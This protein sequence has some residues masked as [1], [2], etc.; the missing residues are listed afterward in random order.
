MV[1]VRV[2][3][4]FFFWG[5]AS[6]L[7]RFAPLPLSPL[8]ISNEASRNLE[9]KMCFGDRV[10]RCAEIE[11]RDDRRTTLRAIEGKEAKI[12]R[13]VFFFERKES[14]HRSKKLETLFFFSTG[15][16]ILVSLSF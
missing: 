6:T 9:D 5:G 12:R 7:D 8:G 11:N 1:W 15:E 16:E 10:R 3:K 4:T 14:G 13:R 2:A